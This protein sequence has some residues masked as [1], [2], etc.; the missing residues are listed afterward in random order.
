MALIFK[1]RVERSK[2]RQ[3][4]EFLEKEHL[5]TRKQKPQRPLCEEDFGILEE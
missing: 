4:C 2:L 1:R 5:R 3:P